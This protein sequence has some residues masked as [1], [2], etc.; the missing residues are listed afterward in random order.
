MASNR[1]EVLKSMLAQDPANA[2]A[3]YGLAMEYVNSGQFEQAIAEFQALF[4]SNPDYPAAYYHAGRT[5]EKL[6]RE[7]D[8]RTIYQRG[9][10]VTTRMGDLHT[11]SEIQAAL[12][13]L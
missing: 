9:I 13:L 6:G 2:F 11:R 8:A 10:E 1:S 7:D 5:F 4:A 12:D 3:R